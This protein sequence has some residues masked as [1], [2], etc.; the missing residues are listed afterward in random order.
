MSSKFKIKKLTN[1]VTLLMCNDPTKHVVKV[2]ITTKFGGDNTEFKID[3][4]KYTI[5]KGMA[6]FLEH[7]LIE[8]SPYGNA[9][10]F[11]TQEEYADFNGFT[12]SDYTEFHIT[13]PHDYLKLLNELLDVVN[14]PVFTQE[15]IDSNKPAI[16]EEINKKADD[17]FSKFFFFTM[18]NTFQK[19]KLKNPLGTKEEI[20]NLKKD[21]VEF[22]YSAFYQPSNQTISISGCFNEEE[23]INLL[24]DYYKGI[25][26]G[27]KVSFKRIKEPLEPKTRY[28]E[29]TEKVHDTY[30]RIT[31]KIPYT[32]YKGI[33]LMKLDYYLNIYINNCFDTSSKVYQ[34]LI[35]KKA[36]DYG[37][38]FGYEFDNDYII[39]FAA[40]YTHNDNMFIDEINKTINKKEYDEEYFNIRKN[41]SVI[42]A[43]IRE[44]NPHSKMAQQKSLYFDYGYKKTCKPKVYDQ[45]NYQEYQEFINEL[46]FDNYLVTKM[47]NEEKK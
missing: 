25:K 2:S 22:A 39:L 23:V 46:S 11:F 43:I 32:K 20:N 16:I 44:D 14:K 31:Y 36:I 10:Q 47:L 28:A 13:T 35:D 42:S 38:S 17:K 29:M 9:F 19:Y 26:K 8:Y 41:Q 4:E 3:K 5:S 15:N 34:K 27:P 21:E 6:H 37:I 1:G 24:N 45:F 40:D 18:D 30:T 7:Y 12:T 33:T